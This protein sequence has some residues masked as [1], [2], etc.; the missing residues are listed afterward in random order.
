MQYIY[1]TIILYRNV[2]LIQLIPLNIAFTC[3][4]LPLPVLGQAP[5][6][7]S[8][9]GAAGMWPWQVSL[10]INGV[11]VCGGT[12]IT[13]R[14]V[15]SAAQSLSRCQLSGQDST[16]LPSSASPSPSSPSY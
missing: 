11:Y 1:H 5:L 13:R 10:L 15:M 9:V 8:I 4:P 2:H 14:Y 3:S 16:S 6:N 12:L 7:T